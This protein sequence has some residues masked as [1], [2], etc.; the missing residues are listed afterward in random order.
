[1]RFG[2]I[3]LLMFTAVAAADVSFVPLRKTTAGRDAE[4]Y[5]LRPDQ[6]KVEALAPLSAGDLAKV[7][8]D[9]LKVY[10]QEQ[11]D[12]LYFR[13][14][15]GP[16]PAGDFRTTLLVKNTLVQAIEAKLV[17][18][19]TTGGDTLQ[20]VF[21]Q[22]LIQYLCKGKDG[23]TCLGDYLWKGKRFYAATPDGTRQMRNAVPNLMFKSLGLK[24]AGLG[25]LVGPLGKARAETFG[26]ANSLMLFPANVYCGSSLIDA[27]RESIIIDYA[28][29]DDFQ[30]Y[31]A[32]IDGLTGRDGENLRD[33]LRMVR[34][35][36]YLGR[37]YI[38]KVFLLNFVLESTA[39]VGAQPSACWAGHSWQ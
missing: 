7:T 26:S 5:S 8:V 32:E 27:R 33:E 12:Q 22:Q 17:Q 19:A 15:S 29:G 14:P 4:Y 37:A 30:P 1:M 39:S 6:A 34:P 13:L 24:L 23:L 9:T 31:I 28:Y 11:L 18:T 2:F 38:D 35:G 36:L 3:A 10:K 25:A 16:F 20:N 21:R